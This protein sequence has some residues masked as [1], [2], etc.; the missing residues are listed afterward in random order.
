MVWAD[1]WFF[2]SNICLM[3]DICCLSAL[4]VSFRYFVT[5]LFRVF[6][7]ILIC[8]VIFRIFWCRWSMAVLVRWGFG[9]SFGIFRLMGLSVLLWLGLL[10]RFRVIRFFLSIWG[11]M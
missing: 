11:R 8:F 10:G 6:C 3:R 9:V 7:S 2:F 4:L 1:F 5:L